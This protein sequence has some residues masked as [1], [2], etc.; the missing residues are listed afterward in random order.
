MP[1]SRIAS[2]KALSA[3]QQS[4]QKGVKAPR[5]LQPPAKGHVNIQEP[6]ESLPRMATQLFPWAATSVFAGRAKEAILR[7]Q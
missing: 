5:E 2:E 7:D 4:S 6:Q 1:A 3:S